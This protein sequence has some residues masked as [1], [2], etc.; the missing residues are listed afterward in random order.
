MTDLAQ[1]VPTLP[2]DI[3]GLGDFSTVLA[4]QLQRDWFLES[5]WIVANPTWSG[6]P[7]LRLACRLPRR[8]AADLLACLPRD[9]PLLLHYEGYGY[10]QRGLPLWLYRA[11][12]RWRQ[13]SQRPLITLFHEVY[14]YYA[15]PPWTSSFW[16]A[17]LQKQLAAGLLRLSDRALTSKQSYATLLRIIGGRQA[18]PVTALPIFATIGEP[19]A[20]PPYPQRARRLVV[21]GHPNSRRLTYQRDRP[22]L[23]RVCR[24]LAIADIADI[25][26][27]TGLALPAIAGL[28]PRELGVLS[29]PEARAAMLDAIAG[30]LSTPGPSYLAKSSVF[31]AYAACGLTPILAA[32]QA[33][34]ADGLQPGQHYWLA[35]N[36]D[37][38]LSAPLAEAIAQQANAWYQPH[39]LAA[40]ARTVA[41]CLQLVPPQAP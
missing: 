38:K 32:S 8:H 39:N 18:A 30:F 2:P 28:Q 21:F 33:E 26:V 10:A 22:A 14:P 11:L 23:E 5:Q 40:Y 36:V 17:P 3:S 34:P 25:G 15:K 16:L 12:R 37:A 41:A 35:G 29:A 1:I 6:D 24:E 20:L 13:E 9:R 31:A 7:V 4:A 27:P 19:S